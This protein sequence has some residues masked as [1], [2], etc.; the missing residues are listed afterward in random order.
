M[1]SF[2]AFIALFSVAAAA[3]QTTWVYNAGYY[4]ADWCGPVLGAKSSYY[5]SDAV[6]NHPDQKPPGTW[7]PPDAPERWVDKVFGY[8]TWKL[9]KGGALPAYSTPTALSAHGKYTFLL[10]R[11]GVPEC[12]GGW[13][14]LVETESGK[15]VKAFTGNQDWGQWWDS[16][17]D[18]VYY[19]VKNKTQIVKTDLSTGADSVVLDLTGKPGIESIWVG[20]TGDLSRDNMVAFIS[21]YPVTAKNDRAWAAQSAVCLARLDGSGSYWCSLPFEQIEAPVKPVPAE[22]DFAMLSKG[23]DST[24]KLRYIVVENWGHIFSFDGSA[25]KFEG[26]APELP[27]AKY[28]SKG[29]GDGACE[30][31]EKCF[32]DPWDHMDTVEL[33]D[34]TQAILSKYEQEKPLYLNSLAIYPLREVVNAA[35]DPTLLKEGVT[36]IKLASG[37]GTHWGCAR[38]TSVCVVSISSPVRDPGDYTSIL[39]PGPYGFNLIHLDMSAWPA[40]QARRHWHGSVA[41]KMANGAPDYYAL[42]KAS[43][44]ADGVFVAGSSNF[45]EDS[46]A[47][48]MK[49]WGFIARLLATPAQPLPP[50]VP[51]LPPPLQCADG[52]DNDGDGKVDLADPGCASETDDDETDPPPPPAQCADGVDNDGDGKVDLADPGC[53]NETD[54]DETD[55]PS[56]PAPAPSN[57]T[58]TAVSTSQINLHWSDNSANEAGFEIERCKVACSS[59]VLIAKVGPDATSYSDTGLSASRT[60]KYRVRAY[61]AAG[62]SSYSNTATAKTLRRY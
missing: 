11:K 26:L 48:G 25:V 27:D 37:T 49:R 35:K 56:P 52:V 18:E 16:A 14:C 32:G 38:N 46:Q 5:P 55:S 15:L 33:P 51:Q 23:V 13:T 24:T 8:E 17:S 9:F 45:G 21:V 53:A 44:S 1:T 40:V 58:A 30:A 29:D 42:P 47:D 60:Y 22:V 12:D 20:G 3:G 41:W 50:V 34:G 61:N 7:T 43:I 2:R 39:D 6:C 19:Q 10:G 4:P 62:T 31:A 59:Y 28:W 36:F 57:L 54:N